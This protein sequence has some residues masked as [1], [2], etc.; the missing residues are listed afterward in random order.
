MARVTI[1]LPH[2]SYDIS[3]EAGALVG[4]G[5][6][7]RALAPH[8]LCGVIADARVWQE[9]GE[10]F[11]ASLDAA[12]YRMK[13]ALLDRGEEGKN[14]ATVEEL[15]ALLLDASLERRSPIL[16]VGGG[17]T[18]DLAGFVAATYLRGVPFLQCPTS[19][20]AMVDSSVGGKTGF[21]V[22]QGKNLIGAFYQPDAVVID[23]L[24]LRSLPAREIRCGLAECIKHA[25]IRDAALFEF[26]RDEMEGVF[27]FSAET[28]IELIRWNVEI[29]AAVVTEDEREKGVRAHLNFGHSFG[30]VIEA[31]VGYGKILHGE[32]VGLGMLAATRVAVEMGLCDRGLGEE[33][34]S[35]LAAAG[36]PIRQELPGDDELDRIMLHDK[37]VIDHRIRLILPKT[38]GSVEIRDDVSAD[39]IHRGWAAIRM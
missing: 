24:I 27:A 22:S 18:G 30:H 20:L 29:K 8:A 11:E 10:R 37:K 34:E 31:S 25:V 7:V 35:L 6:R 36:L 2:H 19:L 4:I 21:N 16:A 1:T 33:L 17:V 13:L 3:I 14:L 28:L 38:L 39:C 15:Y 32:A 5:E 23:P 12:G 9:C 26:I